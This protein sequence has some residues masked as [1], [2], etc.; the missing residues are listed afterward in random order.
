MG[1]GPDTIRDPQTTPCPGASRTIN[2]SVGEEANVIQEKRN[3]LISPLQLSVQLSTW[4]MI[5]V[6]SGQ[7]EYRHASA[8]QSL[9]FRIL[10]CGQTDYNMETDS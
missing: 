6:S 2:I 7:V 10:Y 8:R 9:P 3:Y 5:E 4:G 1:L